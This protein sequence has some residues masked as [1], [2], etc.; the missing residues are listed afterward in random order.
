V[1]ATRRDLLKLSAIAALAAGLPSGWRGTVYASDAPETSKMRFGIIALTDCS[2]IVMAHELGLFKKHGIESTISKEASWAVIRDRLTLGE[3]QASHILL[4]IP[5]A[6]TMGLQGSPVKPMIIPMYLNRNGQAI[7]LTKALLD[8]GV[9]TPQ[10]LRPLALEAKTKGSPMTFAMT[11][12]PGTHAMW[13][14]YW[15]GAGGLNPDRDVTLITIPPAQMVANMKV[16]KMDGYCVG[17]PWGARAIADGIGFTAITTQQIWKDHPEKVL[18]FTE[19]F[20]ARNPKTVKACMRAILEASQWNDKLE[21]RPKM[22]EVVGQPQYVNA[23]KEIILGRMLGDY[24]YGD[25]RK[26]KDKYYMT[27]FDRQTTFPMKSHGTWWLTQFRRWGMVKEAPDYKAIVDRVHRPDIYR[28]VAKEMGIETPRGD[29]QKETF[30][31]GGVFDPSV[32]PEK[33]VKSF[34][35]HTMA[36]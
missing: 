10:Q 31:D 32:D 19:E 36:S 30:F 6:A 1:T 3:N 17:E 27:F 28:E 23:A 8:K 7:T 20:A 2:S 33:Y 24:D 12:P 18:G 4:G 11:Y 26:E 13:T 34:A 22:A 14:R 9:K 35:V 15:L 25:G 16:G 29:A 21:N 5:Y